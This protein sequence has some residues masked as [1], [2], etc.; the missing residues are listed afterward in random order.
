MVD[1]PRDAP[2]FHLEHGKGSGF[3]PEGEVLLFDRLRDVGVPFLS[4]VDFSRVAMEL[5]EQRGENPTFNEESWGMVNLDLPEIELTRPGWADADAADGS[6][7][8]SGIRQGS[9]PR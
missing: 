4:T 3:T 1:L 5:S 7:L 6:S 2:V 9:V 8:S